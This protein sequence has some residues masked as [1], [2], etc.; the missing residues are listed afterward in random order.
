[1]KLSR[2]NGAMGILMLFAVLLLTVIGTRS[3]FAG[4]SSA[5]VSL[6]F[7]S[8]F[9][10]PQGVELLPAGN[11]H[12]LLCGTQDNRSFILLLDENGQLL[13]EQVLSAHMQ[14]PLYQ[15]GKLALVCPYRS[16]NQE[17]FGVSV[18]TYV[19]RREELDKNQSID[20]PQIYVEGKNDFAMDS[21]GRFY[22]IHTPME[23][24]I[25]IFEPSGWLLNQ[26]AS[27]RGPVT[28]VAL[29]PNNVLYTQYDGE[30]KLGIKAM[31]DSI[32]EETNLEEPPLFDSDLPQDGYRFLNENMV[33]DE[34]GNLY[35][36]QQDSGLLHRYT[37]TDGDMECA[38]ALSSSKVLVKT[39]DSRLLEYVDD[40]NTGAYHIPGDLISIAANGDRAAAI[41]QQEED[42][43]FLPI[44]QELLED[45]TS[46]SQEESSEEV[47][48]EPG[49]SSKN[50]ESSHPDDNSSELPERVEIISLNQ[51]VRIDRSAQKIYLPANTTYAALK[52][53]IRVQEGILEAQ[54]P[55]GVSFVS[56]YVMTGAVLLAQNEEGEIS[57]SL[58]VIVQG[59]LSGTGRL[60]QTD[61]KLLYRVLSGTAEL[62]EASFAAADMDG[63]GKITTAD[64]LILKKELKKSS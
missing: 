44:T 3:I 43:I 17:E 31:P 21:K 4:T 62:E 55:N 11:N 8:G 27:T 41:V 37:E 24:S 26:I 14:F 18:Y 59:D 63:D 30:S 61:S 19:V 54:K 53:V 36:V 52:N 60:T 28:S 25:L 38:A 45:E 35:R 50:E 51:S 13:D 46:S 57:D 56:G 33:M 42:W 48:S 22:A 1:M 23:D 16:S 29:S 2:K 20:L 40:E 47:S 9:D 12:Y 32:R 34:S 39:E 6:E 10:D 58:T 49:E 64:L 7:P 15:D 5:A